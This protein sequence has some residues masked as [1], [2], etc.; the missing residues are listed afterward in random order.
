MKK[1]IITLVLLFALS[2][3]AQTLFLEYGLDP[4]MAYEGPYKD[5]PNDTNGGTYNAEYKIGLE[6]DKQLFGVAYETHKAIKY[7]KVSLFYDIKFNDKLL[8][9]NAKRFTTRLGP[10]A[11][12]IIRK[13][14]PEDYRSV[15]HDWVQLGANIGV[16]YNLYHKQCDTG[17][18]IG[19]NYNAFRGEK[20]YR[21][22]ADTFIDTFRTDFN[23]V[24]RRRF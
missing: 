8:I 2:S 21:D 10:E 7:Q 3:N 22:Y 5:K 9:F 24:L 12:M 15:T 13:N 16:F 17:F 18:D 14:P 19:V 6:Y 11:S 23:I 4:K 1:L 20:H